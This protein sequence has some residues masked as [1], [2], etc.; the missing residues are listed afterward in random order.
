MSDEPKTRD[1]PTRPNDRVSIAARAM[2]DAYAATY[3]WDPS[4]GN[5]PSH[6]HDV[7]GVWDRNNGDKAGTQCELCA[8]WNALLAATGWA[9]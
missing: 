4:E 5:C 9:P 8:A 2:L 1:R 7:P 3:Y 6:G